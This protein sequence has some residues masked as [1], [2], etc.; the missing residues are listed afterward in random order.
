MANFPPKIFFDDLTKRDNSKAPAA[1]LYVAG[2]PCQPFSLAGLRQGFADVRGVA[3]SSGTFAT[4][5]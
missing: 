1:D 3:R 4:I 5:R 2:F